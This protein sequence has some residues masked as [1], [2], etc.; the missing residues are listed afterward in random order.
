LLSKRMRR[1]RLAKYKA[2]LLLPWTYYVPYGYQVDPDR[3]RDPAGVRL[4]E[5]KAAVVGEIFATYLEE[6]ASL[7]GVSQGICRLKTSP[8]PGVGRSGA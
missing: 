7:L 2:G 4:D 1:G 8:R 5:A 3:P 6:G